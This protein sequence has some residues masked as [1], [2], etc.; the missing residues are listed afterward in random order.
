MKYQY[1]R[2]LICKASIAYCVVLFLLAWIGDWEYNY[3]ILGGFVA[4]GNI[5][6][7]QIMQ[8]TLSVFPPI[9]MAT[10]FWESES[11][12]MYYF[13][14]LRCKSV[15]QWCHS[16]FETVFFLNA[17]YYILALGLK[18]LFQPVYLFFIES[19]LGGA[20]FILH[21]TLISFTLI[22]IL[23]RF[24]SAHIA[25]SLFCFIEILLPTVGAAI[26]HLSKFLLPFWGMSYYTSQFRNVECYHWVVQSISFI[27]LILFNIII[28][29][30]LKKQ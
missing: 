22:Y 15:A 1:G 4:T 23:T 30:R 3:R 21:T 7:L 11:G 27:L 13:T 9:F 28:V 24:K 5:N 19:L 10:L 16:R 8:W 6:V 18:F 26:P 25:V 2:I 12:N 17:S 29:A 20:Q 14:I